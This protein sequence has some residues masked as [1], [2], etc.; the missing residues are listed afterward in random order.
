VRFGNNAI[1]VYF[2]LIKITRCF[3]IYSPFYLFFLLKSTFS[4]VCQT[5]S[6]ETFAHDFTLATM[7]H[8]IARRYASAIYMLSSCVCLYVRLYLRPSVTR[9]YCTKTAKHRIMQITPYDSSG[10]LIFCCQRSRRNSYGVT[11]NRGREIEAQLAPQ[12]RHS[13]V[14]SSRHPI[15]VLCPRW[16]NPIGISPRSLAIQNW[17]P[18][19]S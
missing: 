4:D 19:L 8:F 9:R 6:L 18:W 3:Y 13:I 2:C 10:S 15:C 17:S 16:G 12:H 14:L 1:N 5:N 11:S 7:N